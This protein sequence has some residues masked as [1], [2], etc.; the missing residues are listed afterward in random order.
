[1]SLTFLCAAALAIDGDTLRCSNI[2]AAR[3]RVRLARIDAPEL[4]GHCRSGR[5]CAQGDGV[6]SRDGLARLIRGTPVKCRQVDASPRNTGFQ[7]HDPYGR[8]VARC[9][10]GGRD[11]GDAMLSARLARRWP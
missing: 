1:M 3:G 6:K 4:P 5:D 2:E 8:I 7:S 9:S 11:L 10:V